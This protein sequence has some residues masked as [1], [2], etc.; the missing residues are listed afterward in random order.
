MKCKHTVSFFT[1]DI[2]SELQP[3]GPDEYPGPDTRW[4]RRPI[5]YKDMCEQSKDY[6]DNKY[7]CLCVYGHNVIK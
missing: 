2:V 7:P 3:R 5:A 4:I 6:V 1:Y